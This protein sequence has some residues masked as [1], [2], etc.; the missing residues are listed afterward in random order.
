VSIT[1]LALAITAGLLLH[2]AVIAVSAHRIRRLRH[3]LNLAWHDV[4]HDQLTGL[5]NRRALDTLLPTVLAAGQPVT[6]GFLDLDGFKQINDAYGHATGDWVLQTVAAR[7]GRH[8]GGVRLVARLGGDEFVLVIDGD[9]QAAADTIAR[10]RVAVVGTPLLIGDR[11]VTIH[12]SAG[13]AHSITG[14]SAGELLHRADWAMHAAK[15]DGGGVRCWPTTEA[16]DVP[17]R[18]ARR[19]RDRRLTAWF[20]SGTARHLTEHAATSVQQRTS[21]TEHDHGLGCPGGLEIAIDRDTVTLHSTGFP[22]PTTS[23]YSGVELVAPAIHAINLPDP[24]QPQPPRYAHLHTDPPL[25][26]A[27]RT[28]P[29]AALLVVA[30]DG[31]TVTWHLDTPAPTTF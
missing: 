28:A 9:D 15:A 7:L 8:R 12:A 30:T 10:A 4:S 1:P 3:Q 11:Q 16:L 14:I 20:D 6:V 18:P 13:I 24:D 26:Q 23:R 19:V 25:L 17:A 29:A 2:G 27:L 22:A 31:V 5:A 21:D